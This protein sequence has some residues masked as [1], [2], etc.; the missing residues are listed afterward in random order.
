MRLLIFGPQCIRLTYNVNLV[1]VNSTKR[2]RSPVR[3][4]VKLV[5][6]S[7]GPELLEPC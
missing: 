2:A 4:D 1:N 6:D 7:H 5:T 3:G